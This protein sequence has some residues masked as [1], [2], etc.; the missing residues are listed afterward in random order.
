MFAYQVYRI[1]RAYRR[2]SDERCDQVTIQV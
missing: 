1:Q 2:V